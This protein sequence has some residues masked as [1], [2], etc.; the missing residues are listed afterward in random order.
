MSKQTEEVKQNC[1]TLFFILKNIQ[2]K[3]LQLDTHRELH[4][5]ER[6]SELSKEIKD[7]KEKYSNE[8]KRLEKI[9]DSLADVRHS[10]ILKLRYINLLSWEDIASISNYSLSYTY[11]LHNSAL[12]ELQTTN[13]INKIKT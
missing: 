3:R 7:L 8:E 10:T 12:K 9:F 4:N 13:S 6:M 11:S 2:I 1:N 5:R